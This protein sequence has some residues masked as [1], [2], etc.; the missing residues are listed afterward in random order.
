[1]K[2][3]VNITFQGRDFSK[4]QPDGFGLTVAGFDLDYDVLTVYLNTDDGDNLTLANKA[5][6]CNE[7]LVPVGKIAWRINPDPAIIKAH[8]SVARHV[9][10]VYGRVIV[11]AGGFAVDDER[12]G[13]DAN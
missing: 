13:T 4:D 5:A 6:M 12:Q 1:M 9:G 8:P 10:E 11:T 2:N 7:E 3:A